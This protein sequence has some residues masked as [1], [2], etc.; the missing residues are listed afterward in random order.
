MVFIA[1]YYIDTEICTLSTLTLPYLSVADKFK[2][3]ARFFSIGQ[4]SVRGAL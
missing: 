1:D 2:G 3:D 4:K